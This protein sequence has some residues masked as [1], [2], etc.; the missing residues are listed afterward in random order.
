MIM[1]A[2]DLDVKSLLEIYSWYECINSGLLINAFNSHYF[3]AN[4]LA[5]TVDPGEIGHSPS[6][7]IPSN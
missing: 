3:I 1:N 2:S 4:Q 7:N 6:G 5:L